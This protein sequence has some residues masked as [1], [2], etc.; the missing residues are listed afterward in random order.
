MQSF[1][2]KPGRL[3]R[4][5][6]EEEQKIERLRRLKFSGYAEPDVKPVDWFYI[7]LEPGTRR[8]LE[9]VNGTYVCTGIEK[10]PIA[11]N[12]TVP[13]IEEAVDNDTEEMESYSTYTL[14]FENEIDDSYLSESSDQ[15]DSNESQEEPDLAIFNIDN[16]YDMSSSQTCRSS[17]LHKVP[18][19]QTCQL[20]GGN[21]N[22]IMSTRR[23]VKTVK[24]RRPR[25][26]RNPNQIPKN[27]R[28]SDINPPKLH[29]IFDYVDP[30]PTVS[31]PTASFR[32]RSFRIN[33][34]WDPD[35][36]VLSTGISGFQKWMQFYEFYR[37]NRV[38]LLWA[39]A[40]NET[41]PLMVGFT[42]SNR[43][44]DTFIITRQE[45]ID[46]LENGFTTKVHILQNR[47]GG[48]STCRLEREIQ[49]SALFGDNNLYYG[50]LNYVGVGLSDPVD[51]IFINL[52]VISPLNTTF[53]LNGTVGVIEFRLFAKL[54]TTITLNDTAVKKARLKNT[55]KEE[56]VQ[57]LKEKLK[58]AY[59]REI[60]ANEM[61]VI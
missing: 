53:L 37:V 57:E 44:Q 2:D 17:E 1:K 52:I 47:N 58:K 11:E 26:K 39:P 6:Y 7:P 14:N 60:K 3:I 21:R 18:Y 9:V 5:Q 32:I 25:K 31:A 35:P 59:E 16:L 20:L 56:S 48:P 36:A 27:L 12:V 38:N 29:R 40:N 8:I 41:F 42:L 22:K 28:G 45:A 24:P 43:A 33:T 55:E 4:Q 51:Q 49:L 54:F 19:M 30:N 34:L 13:T 46:A 61:L 10:I 23:K 50:D 15:E